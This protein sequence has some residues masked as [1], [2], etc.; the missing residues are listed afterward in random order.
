MKTP[1]T[2]QYGNVLE[3]NEFVRNSDGL[4]VFRYDLFGKKEQVTAKRLDLL[5]SKKKKISER[6]KS[7]SSWSLGLETEKPRKRLVLWIDD[8][9]VSS[10]INIALNSGK[11][12]SEIIPEM[13]R[14]YEEN[15]TEKGKAL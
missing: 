6:L 13:I 3:N 5:R 8:E 2:D 12:T 1:R 10:L 14:L 9:T 4:Y 11:K 7:E 15:F